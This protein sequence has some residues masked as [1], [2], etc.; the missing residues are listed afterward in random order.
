MYHKEENLMRVKRP[1]LVL[2]LS[3]VAAAAHADVIWDQQPD[4]AFESE[5]FIFVNELFPRNP[6]GYSNYIVSDVTINEQT[7]LDQITNYYF[8]IS[9]WEL[10]VTVP[11]VVN[12]F[13]SDGSGMPS[14]LLDNPEASGMAVDVVITR[15]AAGAIEATADLS[16]LDLVLD[17]GEYWIALTPDANAAL[18]VGE[19][20][21]ASHF[22]STDVI[23]YGSFGRNPAGGFGVGTDWYDPTFGV[24]PNYDAALTIHGTAV[25]APSSL[26]ILA[27]AGVAS[28]GRRRKQR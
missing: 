6:D 8:D 10:G 4:L 25:P 17:S 27:L 2:G 18:P 16:S 13:T 21:Q 1:L 9:G 26:T 22:P 15:N 28:R 24:Y 20:A 23:G 3:A 19:Q 12:V 7:R 5:Q 11:G 14:N